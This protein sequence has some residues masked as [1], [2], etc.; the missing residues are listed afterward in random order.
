MN[1]ENIKKLKQLN[2]SNMASYYQD[3]NDVKEFMTLDFDSRLAVLL[4]FEINARHNKKIA[5]LAKK[6]NFKMKPDVTTIDFSP[7]R[8]LNRE[9]FSILSSCTWIGQG[10][11]LVVS[12]ATGTGKTYIASAR[13]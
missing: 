5:S 6:A 1:Q 12:G 8:N 9:L 10:K 13:L 4:D 3:Y 7:E 2:L 11:N